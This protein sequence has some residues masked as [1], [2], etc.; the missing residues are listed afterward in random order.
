MQA[1]LCSRRGSRPGLLAYRESAIGL[2]RDAR[3]DGA[4]LRR[5]HPA[6]WWNPTEYNVVDLCA[7]RDTDPHAVG[8]AWGS[9]LKGRTVWPLRSL[10]ATSEGVPRRRDLR[11]RAKAPVILFCNNN[12]W[13]ISTR[14]PPRRPRRRSPTRRS[15]AFRCPWTGPTCSRCTRPPRRGTARV[16]ETPDVHRG[17][18]VP[19]GAAC[20]CRQPLDL[21]RR[22]PRRGSTRERVLVASPATRPLRVLTDRSWRRSR[23]KR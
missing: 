10:G 6:G 12:Q 16:P 21:R 18:D 22:R 5:G 13:A 9:A 19:C 14:S 4:V 1:G 20:D 17:G 11:R 7:D 15:A 2:L 3:F 23:Q 8:F